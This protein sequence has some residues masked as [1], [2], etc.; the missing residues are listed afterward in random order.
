MG[1]RLNLIIVIIMARTYHQRLS[2]EGMFIIVAGKCYVKGD[3]HVENFDGYTYTV[4]GVGGFPCDFYL[5]R[6]YVRCTW[7]LRV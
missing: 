1:I 6:H 3:P 5:A 7:Y 4:P 2:R